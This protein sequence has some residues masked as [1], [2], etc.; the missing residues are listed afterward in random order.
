MMQKDKSSLL[1]RISV[2]RPVTVTMC[3]IALLV[4]GAMA[5]SLIPVKMFPSG[6]TRPFLYVRINYP[7]STHRES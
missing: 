4:L 6:F 2:T 3:L 7:N 5:Y 1:P